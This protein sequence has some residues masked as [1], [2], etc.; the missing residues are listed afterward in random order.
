[1]TFRAACIFF[2]LL[3]PPH[4][5]AAADQSYD[6]TFDGGCT[7]VQTP[8]N[9]IEW[10]GGTY[11]AGIVYGYYHNVR[12]V[13]P[14]MTGAKVTILASPKHGTLRPTGEMGTGPWYE[15]LAGKGYRGPDDA[16]FVIDLAGKQ[17]KVHEKFYV[18]EKTNDNNF[19]ETGT[20]ATRCAESEGKRIVSQQIPSTKV[21]PDRKD[22]RAMAICMPIATLAEDKVMFPVSAAAEYFLRYNDVEFSLEDSS[23][24]ILEPP[25][26][27]ELVPKGRGVFAYEPRSGYLGKDS[28]LLEVH[29]NGFTVREIYH[30]H[31]VG[32]SYPIAGKDYP[33]ERKGQASWTKIVCSET[34]YDPIDRLPNNSLQPTSHAN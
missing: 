12:N 3:A 9:Q 21:L 28:A 27:G 16:T 15:F 7:V 14:D 1:M 29:I 4:L 10:S 25:Q 5:C 34:N 19:Y 18:V 30:F 11:P 32:P 2:F 6:M 20:P 22:V 26:H 24:L 13:D 31:V 33:I 23:L 8:D 17:Y